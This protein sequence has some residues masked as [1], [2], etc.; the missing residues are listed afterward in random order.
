M[1]LVYSYIRK[2]KQRVNIDNVYREWQEIFFGVLQGSILGHSFFEHCPLWY[3]FIVKS[4]EIEK[5]VFDITRYNC[6]KEFD[7]IFK[8]LETAG[9]EISN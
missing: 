8:K 1:K 7:L 9:N 4:I 5:Y 2:R 6:C 3:F